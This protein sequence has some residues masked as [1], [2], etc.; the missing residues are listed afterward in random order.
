[1]VSILVYTP[2][3]S[4]TA[5]V[6]KNPGPG[7]A[8]SAFQASDV[9]C[10]VGGLTFAHEHGHN[11]G[12]EHNIENSSAPGSASYP[13]SFGQWANASYRTVMSYSDPCAGGCPRISKFSN[14]D[15]DHNGVPTG[16][17]GSRDN[18]RTGDLTGPIAVDF[19]ASV[20]P[21][22]NGGA[23]VVTSFIVTGE[24]DV[25][26]RVNTGAIILD[27]TDIELGADGSVA[28]VVGL[29]FQNLEIPQGATIL[30]ATLGFTV[31]EID[32]GATNLVIRAQAADDAPAFTSA[33]SN[34]TGRA[35][36]AAST[37]WNVPAWSAIHWSHTSPDL[38]DVVQE[39]VDRAGW[40]PN[41]SM[42]FVISGTGE[43]TAEA[44]EGGAGWPATL[45][46][47]HAM[48]V[49]ALGA[50]A[51]TLLILGL[52]GCGVAAFARRRFV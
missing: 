29:R 12:M 10:A 38:A 7:F 13:W 26:E 9:D 39:V 40:S 14:P 41:H 11:L 25:E 18:A 20:V 51:R 16:A 37:A 2:S 8:S 42:V 45:H 21:P 50:G 33:A 49:P 1:M 23:A 46:V 24:D 44:F 30:S 31:D 17:D 19:R 28:Q 5:Y 48:A 15:V 27:S 36:T 22:G 3:S 43:R 35:L 47:E 52:A 4:G 32:T 6:Q 34:V